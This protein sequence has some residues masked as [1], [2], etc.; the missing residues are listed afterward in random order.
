MCRLPKY[1]RLAYFQNNIGRGVLLQKKSLIIMTQMEYFVTTLCLLPR[2]SVDS[3]Q[4]R[5]R[6]K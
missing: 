5:L 6:P 2:R 4:S 1:L 3:R